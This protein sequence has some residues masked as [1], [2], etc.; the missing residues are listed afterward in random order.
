M[1][2]VK[3][4]DTKNYIQKIEKYTKKLINNSKTKKMEIKI[5]IFRKLH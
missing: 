3:N 4:N 1:L 5:E 2:Y